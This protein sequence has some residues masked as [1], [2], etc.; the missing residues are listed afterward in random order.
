MI[1][2]HSMAVLMSKRKKEKGIK[3]KQLEQL[4]DSIIRTQQDEINI[5]KGLED[6]N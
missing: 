2:H 5:L 6:K 4:I 3:D 1:Q